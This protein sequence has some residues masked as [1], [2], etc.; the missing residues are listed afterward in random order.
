MGTGNDTQKHQSSQ[1]AQPLS[2]LKPAK[3]PGR[4]DEKLGKGTPQ[5]STADNDQQELGSKE[6]QSTS[7]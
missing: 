4:G 7:K 1:H 2:G 6:Q 5:P 3:V